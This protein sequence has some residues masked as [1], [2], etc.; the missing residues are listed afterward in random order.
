[1]E[2]TEKAQRSMFEGQQQ[3]EIVMADAIEPTEGR[4]AGVW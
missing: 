3:H 1:M 2:T 4:L